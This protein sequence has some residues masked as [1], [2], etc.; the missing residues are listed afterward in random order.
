MLKKFFSGAIFGTGF[1]IAGLCIYTAWMFFV[2]PLLIGQNFNSEVVVTENPSQLQHFVNT[3]NF[4]ELSV[5]KKIEL[6]TAII[7]VKF[8]EGE[9]GNYISVVED[10]L[11]K[12]EGVQL[13][14]NVGEL[15]EDAS[16]YKVADEYVP[17]RAIIFMQGN[18]ATMRFST[19]FEGERVRGLGG[20]SLA[21]LREKC[22][23]T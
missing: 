19:T 7:I 21:L 5:D 9:N 13:Y 12:E 10:I 15:Y 3:P 22:S 17:T 11:K 8:E 14:Y 4:H 1:S 2:L 6:A 20:I 23:D 18:P 16:H